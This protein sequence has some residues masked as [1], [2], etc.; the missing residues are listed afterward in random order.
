MTRRTLQVRTVV[1]LAASI[2]LGLGTGQASANPRV[3]NRALTVT[4]LVVSQEGTAQ[5]SLGTGVLVDAKRR[6]VLTALHVVGN[7]PNA[8]VFFPRRDANREPITDLKFYG[9]NRA[10]LGRAG[11]VIATLPAKDLALIQLDVPLRAGARAI[12]L[13][14]SSPHPGEKVI[15][16]GNSNLEEKSLWRYS[17]GE[18]RTVFAR[19]W[20]VREPS[21]KDEKDPK[22]FTPYRSWVIE[23][24]AGTNGG[25]SGAPVLNEAGQLVGIHHGRNLNASLIGYAIDIREIKAFLESVATPAAPAAP[26]TAKAG[27]R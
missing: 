3:Y 14:A 12:P 13:A 10:K 24:S 26:P 16:V 8:Q 23:N 6:W 19:A 22:A 18:V 7:R 15:V 21:V 1:I 4:T 5:P 9:D 27:L 25:D 11:R 2:T 20:A 17:S